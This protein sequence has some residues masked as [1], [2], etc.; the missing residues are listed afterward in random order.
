MKT[1]ERI[2]F[3]PLARK[4]FGKSWLQRNIPASADSIGYTDIPDSYYFDDKTADWTASRITKRTLSRVIA[5]D[6]ISRRRSNYLYLHN[7]LQD[8]EGVHLLFQTLPPW[9]C[10]LVFPLVVSDRRRWV[11][12]LHMRGIAAI[13]WWAGYHRELR[14]E[15]FTEARFLKD[16]LLVLPIHQDLDQLH[17]RFI[18]MCV[19]NIVQL[20]SK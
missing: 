19:R 12:E 8:V 18:E 3:Y 16:R 13:A 9:V 11:A 10:P 6:I 5:D 17:M 20:V 1:S 4:L 14:W 15:E 2:G 7:S